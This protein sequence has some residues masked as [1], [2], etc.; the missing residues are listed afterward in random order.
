MKYQDIKS[1]SDNELVE[2]VTSTRFALQ[3]ERLKDRFSKKASI[4]RNAKLVI[5][6]ALTELRTRTTK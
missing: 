3:D 1:K 2:L 4:I 6:R 5:A